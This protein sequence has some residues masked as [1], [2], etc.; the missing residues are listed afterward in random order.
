MAYPRRRTRSSY[1]RGR[2][3]SRSGFSYQPRYRP[4]RPSRRQRLR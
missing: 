2:Y 4:P 1:G 3:R